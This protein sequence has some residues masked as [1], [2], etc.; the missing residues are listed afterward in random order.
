M[1]TTISVDQH[2]FFPGRSTAASA[3][4]FISYVHE[5]FDLKQQVDV[6]FTDFSKAF[7]SIDHGSLAFILDR[8]GVGEPL[9]S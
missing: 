9:L 7:D 6:I 4:D 3:V 5:A 2:G 8:L 1:I